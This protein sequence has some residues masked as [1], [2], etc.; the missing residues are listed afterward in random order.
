MTDP[1]TER[2]SRKLRYHNRVAFY[3]AE[4]GGFLSQ[5]GTRH[6]E[7]GVHVE[8]SLRI[9]ERSKRNPD[10]QKYL[11]EVIPFDYNG[12]T[13]TATQEVI[14]YGDKVRLRHVYTQQYLCVKSLTMR[15]S[16]SWEGESD[17][18]KLSLEDADVADVVKT[19]HFRIMPSFRVRQEGQPIEADDEVVIQQTEVQPL[20]FIST[21][22]LGTNE[23]KTRI[24]LLPN[25]SDEY[26]EA[27]LSVRRRTYAVRAYDSIVSDDPFLESINAEETDVHNRSKPPIKVGDAILLFHKDYDAFVNIKSGL[28]TMHRVTNST[29]K[30]RSYLSNSLFTIELQ[31][32]D[33]GGSVTIETAIRIRHLASGLYLWHD[34][35]GLSLTSNLTEDSTLWLM[36]MQITA[37]LDDGCQFIRKKNEPLIRDSVVRI[38]GISLKQSVATATCWLGTESSGSTTWESSLS[39]CSRKK[40]VFQDAFQVIAAPQLD[41]VHEIQR[42]IAAKPT[43]SEYVNWWLDKDNR[44]VTGAA[45]MLSLQKLIPKEGLMQAVL[46]H[47]TR[48]VKLL[49]PPGFTPLESGMFIFYVLMES[50]VN[51]LNKTFTGNSTLTDDKPRPAECSGNFWTG[52][53]Q[54]ELHM[55]YQQTM[56]DQEMHE[57]LMAC[58]TVPFSEVPWAVEHLQPIEKIGEKKYCLTK[59]RFRAID[60]GEQQ[61]KTFKNICTTVYS[62]LLSLVRDNGKAA[63]ALAQPRH[64]KVMRE[65]LTWYQI[66]SDLCLEEILKHQQVLN[67]LDDDLIPDFCS[68]LSKLSV[69]GER[70]SGSRLY[71]QKPADGEC[72]SQ[73]IVQLLNMCCVCYNTDEEIPTNQTQVAKYFLTPLKNGNF[74]KGLNIAI[75]KIGIGGR[76]EVRFHPKDSLWLPVRHVSQQEIQNMQHEAVPIQEF[77]E[78]SGNSQLMSYNVACIELF[79]ALIRGR[80]EFSSQIQA[81]AAGNPSG[82]PVVD[83]VK[84]YFGNPSEFI[85]VL[86]MLD[87]QKAGGTAGPGKAAQLCPAYATLTKEW[88]SAPSHSD[89]CGFV[90]YC[91]YSKGGN[92]RLAKWNAS[93]GINNDQGPS[94]LSVPTISNIKEWIRARASDLSFLL[95]NNQTM[96]LLLSSLKLCRQLIISGYYAKDHSGEQSSSKYAH[97]PLFNSLLSILDPST[98]GKHGS[99]NILTAAQRRQYCTENLPL[100]KTKLEVVKI[101]NSTIDECVWKKFVPR[102]LGIHDSTGNDRFW[103][104]LSFSQQYISGCCVD[105]FNE[106]EISNHADWLKGSESSPPFNFAPSVSPERSS[107]DGSIKDLTS[108]LMELM[109]YQWQPMVEA[110]LGLLFRL[111]AVPMEVSS[112]IDKVVTL[113]HRNERKSYHEIEEHTNILLNKHNDVTLCRD[114]DVES[115]KAADLV[116]KSLQTLCDRMLEGSGDLSRKWAEFQIRPANTH[117]QRLVVSTDITTCVLAIISTFLRFEESHATVPSVIPFEEVYQLLIRQ[118]YR[119][120]AVLVKNNPTASDHEQLLSWCSEEKLKLHIRHERRPP[121]ESSQSSYERLFPAWEVSSFFIE[122]MLHYQCCV[123]FSTCKDL[124]WTLASQLSPG[125]LEGTGRSPRHLRILR[126]MILVKESHYTTCEHNSGKVMEVTEKVIDSNLATVLA[127]LVAEKKRVLIMFRDSNGQERE[128]KEK[129][130]KLEC[131]AL[132][133]TTIELMGPTDRDGILQY[134]I[135]LVEL[136]ACGLKGNI[137]IMSPELVFD[138]LWPVYLPTPMEY[139]YPLFFLRPYLLLLSCYINRDDK[140]AEILTFTGPV[141][142]GN[143][144]ALSAQTMPFCWSI[145]QFCGAIVRALSQSEKPGSQYLLKCYE[146]TKCY[147]WLSQQLSTNDKTVLLPKH[148]P[149]W[150]NKD[151]LEIFT[152]EAIIPFLAAVVPRVTSGDSTI[153]PHGAL[154]KVCRAIVQVCSFCNTQTFQILHATQRAVVRQLLVSCSHHGLVP[155]RVELGNFEATD[156]PQGFLS[157]LKKSI[158][159]VSESLLEA[160]AAPG[161]SDNATSSSITNG[162]SNGDVAVAFKAFRTRFRELVYD[163]SCYNSKSHYD[164]PETPARLLAFSGRLVNSSQQ[165]L[166]REYLCHESGPTGDDGTPNPTMMTLENFSIFADLLVSETL[167]NEHVAG[168][169]DVM[170]HGFAESWKVGILEVQRVKLQGIQSDLAKTALDIIEKRKGEIQLLFNRKKATQKIFI[171][172]EISLPRQ[173]AKT[174]EIQVAAVNLLKNLLDGGLRGQVQRTIHQFFVERS[175]EGFFVFCREQLKGYELEL[176]SW[177]LQTQDCSPQYRIRLSEME[178]FLR[179]LQL[180]C[181]GHMTKLQ[182]YLREQLNNPFS[183]NVVREV[184]MFVRYIAKELTHKSVLSLIRQGFITLTEFCQGPCKGNQETLVEAKMPSVVG[185]LLERSEDDYKED[186][187]SDGT[188]AFDDVLSDAISMLLSLTEGVTSVSSDDCSQAQHRTDVP[189]KLLNMLR[190]NNQTNLHNLL[191]KMNE[192]WIKG[193][194][195]HVTKMSGLLWQVVGKVSG[196]EEISAEEDGCHEELQLGFNIFIFIHS[197]CRFDKVK[198]EEHEESKLLKMLK[199]QMSF[200]FFNEHVGQ[201][202]IGR[203][204]RLEKVYFVLPDCCKLLPEESK[205]N[206]QIAVKR[207]SRETKIQDFFLSW[208]DLAQEITIYS[209]ASKQVCVFVN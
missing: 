40:Q 190:D 200:A 89:G 62:A 82:D 121:S 122:L 143:T 73:R 139:S 157:V 25:R 76:A 81:S 6:G 109:L 44:P 64:L 155:E 99:N 195:V 36:T 126:Q 19:S 32:T 189:K 117:I 132:K 67:H 177:D 129:L 184:A 23:V 137:S 179:T 65:Q 83:I 18:L 202:E 71:G 144:A 123:Y 12:T 183:I 78:K 20:H 147:S 63:V 53:Q 103:K 92:L 168:V 127:Y 141:K 30:L 172:M 150:F 56:L 196:D 113:E 206:L 72:V 57:M 133:K 146:G 101:I 24:D 70:E 148:L 50:L 151:E 110:S 102:V 52:V 174:R 35:D 194:I 185:D 111:H 114:N 120:L 9:S 170:A 59:G 2:G 108:H 167:S 66:R 41:L 43:I 106:N 49:T 152:I 130:L 176:K 45:E 165:Y 47:L 28:F 203:D 98:D 39:L 204:E 161:C 159:K 197:L 107:N 17:N 74:P 29:Q 85:P 77:A 166:L 91:E 97:K 54:S 11:F 199:N 136:F 201:I 187:T 205:S 26:Y 160:S 105:F 186:S 138:V 61:N 42:I 208:S 163:P 90:I 5:L 156:Q 13:N 80:F 171:L 87:A 93:Q 154:R 95:Q 37:G 3:D 34:V 145:V 209:E 119:F 51:L 46:Y 27:N 140:Y 131:D 142:T 15:I 68:T 33:R 178:T 175:T 75:H 191:S 21:S 115:N 173:S 4:I 188:T 84:K 112:S 135:E 180:L 55:M 158:K 88:L 118:C 198:G 104:R 182:N 149:V 60:L 94:Q 134:H 7:V 96:K 69:F 153:L 16:S 116:I 207:D 31:D 1:S 38:A 14:S 125:A 124:I 164:G 10:Y 192:S 22:Q 181:E 169:L 8:A 193:H 162:G 48:F 100:F 58:V 86:S 79:G 128:I